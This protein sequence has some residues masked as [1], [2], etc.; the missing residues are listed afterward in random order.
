MRFEW[1]SERPAV[2]FPDGDGETEGDCSEEAA[3][4]PALLRKRTLTPG[5]IRKPSQALGAGP[6]ELN[7]DFSHPSPEAMQQAHKRGAPSGNRNRLVHG[8]YSRLCVDFRARVRAHI[9]E[10][11]ALVA[12]TRKM[13]RGDPEGIAWFG[14]IR[15][16]PGDDK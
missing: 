9:H 12:A 3:G 11:R 6:A 15:E 13:M 16:V 7:P 5:T 4:R 8:K 1:A 2:V 14:D 10:A